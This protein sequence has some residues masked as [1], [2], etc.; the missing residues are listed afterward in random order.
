MEDQNLPPAALGP[1]KDP[2]MLRKLMIA[3]NIRYGRRFHYFDFTFVPKQGWFCWFE[4]KET[5]RLRQDDADS[6]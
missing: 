5:D 2:M 4:L 1:A 6:R 3:N